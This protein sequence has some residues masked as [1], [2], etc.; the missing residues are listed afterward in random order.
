MRGRSGF[1]WLPIWLTLGL[2]AAARPAP[3]Q[4]VIADLSEHLVAITTGF[5][6]VDVLLFGAVDTE[7]DVLITVR[8]PETDTVVRQKTQVNGIWINTSAIGFRNVPGYY[9]IA[10]SR[11]LDEFMTNA[12]AEREQIGIERLR[13]TPTVRLRPEEVTPYREALVRNMTRQGL[14]QALTGTVKFLGQRLF[15]ADL[16]FPA[17]VPTGTYAV[18]V[19]LIRDGQV[20]SA[21]TTPL[22][23]SKIGISAEIYDYAQ[24]QALS[25]GLIAVATAL[26]A[27]WAASRIF[28]RG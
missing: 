18:N 8:G 19:Y 9:A 12:I 1:V 14:F 21:A 10:A 25:Y 26:M 17:N 5:A 13:L 23:V 11:P 7:G 28:Q 22:L 6:G 3:A 4:Q 20:V 16:H 27:G 2:L 15:R 24:Q